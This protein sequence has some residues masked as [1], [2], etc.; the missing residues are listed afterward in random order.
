ML[1]R[2][3]DRGVGALGPVQAFGYDS[4]LSGCLALGLAEVD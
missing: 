4:L 3:A 2:R 1:A